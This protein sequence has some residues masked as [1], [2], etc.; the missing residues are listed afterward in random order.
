MPMSAI[1][2]PRSLALIN[3][4]RHRGLFAGE[5]ATHLK[6][7]ESLVNRYEEREEPPYEVLLAWG[8]KLD[9]T[10]ENVEW[11]VFGATEGCR[12]APVEG[13]L[14]DPAPTEVLRIRALA[15]R[16]CRGLYQLCEEI[17][18]QAARAWKLRRDRREAGK[19]FQ[20]LMK[21][22]MKRRMA[23]LETFPEYQTWAV[24]ERLAHES[25]T[26][27]SDRADRA[28]ELAQ[29]AVR[30]AELT[31]GDEAS[32][33]GV[34]G[35]ALIFLAN[36]RR[37]ANQ[38][39][40]AEADCARGLTLWAKAPRRIQQVLGAWRIKDK[41]GSLRRDQRR[42]PEALDCLKEAREL[43]PPAE[44]ARVLVNRAVVLEHM[45]NSEQAVEVLREA[46]SRLRKPTDPLRLQVLG[47]LAQNLTHLGEFAAAE[48]LLPALKGL[49]TGG[50][51]ELVRVRVA[52]LQARCDAGGGRVAEARG[53][54]EQVRGYFA[55][56][57]MPL[58]YAMASLE[59]AV[60]DLE[61]GRNAEVR[62]L[63]LEMHWIF[64]DQGLAPEA[65]KALQLFRTAAAKERVTAALAR[66]L[67]RYLY[68][69]Q[70]D[71]TLPFAAEGWGELAELA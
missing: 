6:V 69:A 65:A 1:A 46:E 16:L 39:D 14:L 45:G 15:G 8:L 5:L 23:V 4:R 50:R 40:G 2:R 64:E 9:F 18:L 11:Y 60:L 29:L 68:R 32:R 31:P 54:F 24:S 62:R 59:R 26:A 22:P 28:L 20:E 37:V 36:A 17:L 33:S 25:E 57:T 53:G 67:V 42:Y 71:P 52:W 61:A 7:P 63:A 34:L 56:H 35:A 66:Q 12:E 30:A 55:K 10:T 47:N 70:Y 49:A 38:L 43:A 41:E 13:S 21:T 48:A 3:M 19:R 58:D 44:V 51:Q 27:A